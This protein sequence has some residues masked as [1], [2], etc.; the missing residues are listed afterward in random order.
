MHKW[1]LGSQWF[2]LQE[3]KVDEDDLRGVQK[4]EGGLHMNN[5]IHWSKEMDCALKKKKFMLR[6]Q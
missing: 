2:L 6:I 1:F 4:E 5:E 3:T